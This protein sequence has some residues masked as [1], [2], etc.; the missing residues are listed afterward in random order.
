MAEPVGLAASAITL[1]EIVTKLVK[2]VAAIRNAPGEI[3]ALSNEAADL[4]LI[5]SEVQNLVQDKQQSTERTQSLEK[6][7]IRVN[8]TIHL[9]DDF[10]SSIAH[11]TGKR[12]SVNSIRWAIRKRKVNALKEALLKARLDITAIVASMNL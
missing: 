6:V 11:P 7:L 10:I 1:A 3:L 5:V 12:F 8:R 9:L 4:N 2:F